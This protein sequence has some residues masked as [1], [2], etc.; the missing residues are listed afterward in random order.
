MRIIRI[1]VA[2]R[3]VSASSPVALT[4]PSAYRSNRPTAMG[5]R[6]GSISSVC[7]GAGIRRKPSP[8]CPPG[9]RVLPGATPSEVL[10]HP[11]RFMRSLPERHMAAQPA[12][13][14]PS[15]RCAA[16]QSDPASSTAPHPHAQGA[17]SRAASV[18]RARSW[19]ASYPR[20]CRL[21][22]LRSHAAHRIPDGTR[23]GGCP[24]SQV[25]ITRPAD[26]FRQSGSRCRAVSDAGD[27]G[28]HARRH[29]HERG[30]RKRPG[31]SASGATPREPASAT[32][33]DER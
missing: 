19:A 33:G 7:G 30:W 5:I 2:A 4:L 16:T 3:P 17:G 29:R 12:E 32:N 23:A 13:G 24:L 20:A 1:R 9:S 21:G 14:S 18:A 26:A 25:R 6:S 10:P 31:L 11:L 8:A 22:R 15:T 28:V 27:A